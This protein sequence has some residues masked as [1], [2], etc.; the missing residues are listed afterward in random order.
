MYLLRLWK[1]VHQRVLKVVT[2]CPGTRVRCLSLTVSHGLYQ[3]GY[4]LHPDKYTSIILLT[5]PIWQ[6]SPARYR[7]RAKCVRLCLCVSYTWADLSEPGRA[8]IEVDGLEA[9]QLSGLC[10]LT[11]RHTHQRI[12]LLRDHQ[13]LKHTQRTGQRE[14]KVLCE[15]ERDLK[16]S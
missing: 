1:K 5:R 6:F 2:Y 16:T 4:H 7:K 3:P 10:A 8:G 12:L 13:H 9:N 15:R 14:I 11:D